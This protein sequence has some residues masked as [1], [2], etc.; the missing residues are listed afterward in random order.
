MS[1]VAI[2]QYCASNLITKNLKTCVELL[3]KASN[4]GAKMIF[5]PEASD[6]IAKDS[7]E[8]L[9]LTLSIN[10]S[11]FVNGIK[12]AALKKKMWV[13]IGIHELSHDP[14]RIYN[15]HLLI[16]SQGSII[17]TYRKLHLF[18]VNIK[19]GP[20]LLE[21][22]Y[23]I[24]GEKICDPTPTPL[25]N[26]GLMVCYDLRFPELSLELRKK[27]ADILTFPS[28]FTVKTG[29]AHWEVLLR[30]RAIENQCYVIA[31][32]QIGRHNEK[33]IS[34]GHAMIVDPWGTILARCPETNEPSLAFAEIDLDRLKRI[35]TEIP[36]SN[37]RRTD[38]FG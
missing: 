8:T 6:F 18:D 24:R 15:T 2:A 13:S 11:P 12:D 5:F 27:G 29:Q 31:S 23:T 1:F 14:K 33:R 21:S 25:G 28:V 17:E 16:D 36:V 9:S 22:K 26:L 20:N 3:E 35:R 32:A 37:H 34:Y 30:A 19:D 7:E 4:Y 38:L 10:N